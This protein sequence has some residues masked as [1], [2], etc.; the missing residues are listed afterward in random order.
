MLSSLA[1]DKV[2]SQ[3]ISTVWGNPTLE[4]NITLIPK[5]LTQ[6]GAR[7]AGIDIRNIP[8]TFPD[9]KRYHVFAIGH[10]HSG[11][12]HQ[13]TYQIGKWQ[14]LVE[15][16]NDNQAYIRLS[17]L[18][19]KVVPDLAGCYLLTLQGNGHFLIVPDDGVKSQLHM[20]LRGSKLTPNTT[21]ESTAYRF[22]LQSQRDALATQILND[23][24]AVFKE[25]YVDNTWIDVP[26][27]AQINAASH[28]TVINDTSIEQH[29]EL[30]MDT[31]E[32]YTVDDKQYYLLHYPQVPK[33]MLFNTNDLFVMLVREGEGYAIH[34]GAYPGIIT[35]LAGNACGLSTDE[36]ESIMGSL[37]WTYGTTKLKLLLGTANSHKPAYN[38]NFQR[39][40]DTYP[41]ERQYAALLGDVEAPDFITAPVRHGALVNRLINETYDTVIDNVESLYAIGELDRILNQ[42]IKSGTLVDNTMATLANTQGKVT[43]SF[44]N[45]EVNAVNPV[46]LTGNESALWIEHKIETVVRNISVPLSDYLTPV[47]YKTNGELA[48]Y[49]A[50]YTISG[51]TLFPL[52]QVYITELQSSKVITPTYSVSTG[53]WTVDNLTQWL[54]IMDIHVFMDNVYLHPN[55]DYR[56]TET[57]VQLW[58]G[59]NIGVLTLRMSPKLDV[60]I[61]EQGFTRNGVLSVN[62]SYLIE[63]P[64][65]VAVFVG[66]TLYLASEIPWEEDY[67]TSVNTLPNG[68]PYT[69][70]KRVLNEYELTADELLAKRQVHQAKLNQLGTYLNLTPP[71]E[72]T[73]NSLYSTRYKLL[74]PFM[75]RLLKGM[76]EG[77]INYGRRYIENVGIRVAIGNSLLSQLDSG[78]D[79]FSVEW[80]T[81]AIELAPHLSNTPETVSPDAYFFLD[82][83]NRDLLNGKLNLNTYYRI[84]N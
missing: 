27:H 25:Y 16:M 84:H 47:V 52:T 75:V 22:T 69:V 24:D 72:I 35:Q 81:V 26:T 21:I 9:D 63:D 4:L 66:N 5:R 3:Y 61:L 77:S 14:P 6:S 58:K 23:E 19:T 54:A 73:D 80:E 28:V 59:V 15:L 45:G 36:V 49:G 67:L 10:L 7:R 83:V 74:S 56:F 38:F 64:D 78:K 46:S 31:L 12:L 82:K 2:L 17:Y 1:Q 76:R 57:G 62:G 50:D 30:D 13:T 43:L 68:V 55:V 42:G 71:T 18:N 70:M 37:G 33:G 53:E 29:V 20:T 44:I 79:P 48:T 39:T 32:T 11:I 41:E 8:L 60:C 51:D 34:H 65:N 40:W